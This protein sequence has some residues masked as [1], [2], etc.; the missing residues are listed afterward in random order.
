MR[1]EG[2]RD[3]AGSSAIGDEQRAIEGDGVGT[4]AAVGE[5]ERRLRRALL[6]H[7]WRPRNK[8]LSAPS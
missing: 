3:A 1:F 4:I 8:P 7:P 2:R 5:I 6:A